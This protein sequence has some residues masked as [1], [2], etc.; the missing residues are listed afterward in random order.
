MIADGHMTLFRFTIGWKVVL[1]TPELSMPERLVLQDHIAG[2]L[3]LTEALRECLRRPVELSDEGMQ[4]VSMQHFEDEIRRG[5]T[6][7]RDPR[8]S[9]HAEDSP[10][11]N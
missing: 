3:S 2:G 10:F 4:Q 5:P 9:A 6:Y 8:T 1:D 11:F 7:E